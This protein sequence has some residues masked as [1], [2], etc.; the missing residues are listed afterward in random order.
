M[1]ELVLPLSL[2]SRLSSGPSTKLRYEHSVPPAAGL[3]KPSCRG[4]INAH[5]PQEM[6]PVRLW[7][8][9]GGGLVAAATQ[10]EGRAGEERL[11]PPVPAGSRSC[12][13]LSQHHPLP[14]A[15]RPPLPPPPSRTGLRRPRPSSP[16]AGAGQSPRT[17]CRRPWHSLVW[18]E[19]VRR[20]LLT[21]FST[22]TPPETEALEQQ[23]DWRCWQEGTR[24]RWPWA[25]RKAA[26]SRLDASTTPPTRGK[27]G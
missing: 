8:G 12:P 19:G 18:R 2:L 26:S 20:G 11:E 24:K 21:L 16:S 25:A 27:N 5:V 22:P 13:S 10:G 14:S 17:R 23:W 15:S 6:G 4:K 7:W 1:W 3:G 9:G